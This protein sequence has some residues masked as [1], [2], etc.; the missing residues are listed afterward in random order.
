MAHPVS[1]G[2]I[3]R[4]IDR[5]PIGITFSDKSSQIISGTMYAV[6]LRVSS[7]GAKNRTFNPLV[8][9]VCKN[10]KT[11][12]LK[13]RHSN[14]NAEVQ[15]EGVSMAVLQYIDPHV[16]VIVPHGSG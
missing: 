8:T 9:T 16:D 4:H 3:I 1:N 6:E 2:K 7:T 10:N 15:T 13:N 12:C 5:N 11:G 14:I